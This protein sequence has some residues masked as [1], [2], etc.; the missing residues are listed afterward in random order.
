VTRDPIDSK[1]KWNMDQTLVTKIAAGSV[2]LACIMT[3]AMAGKI[4]GPTAA[5][6][7][8]T[9]TGVFLGGAAALGIGQGIANALKKAS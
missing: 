5:S 2:G 7:I 8:Q 3:L 4:D 6:A 1:G 9:I